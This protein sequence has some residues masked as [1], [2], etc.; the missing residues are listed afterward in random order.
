[1]YCIFMFYLD[2]YFGKMFSEVKVLNDI[3]N[4]NFSEI[5]RIV[6]LKY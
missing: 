3:F 4:V 1:M 2:Y 5:Y 6:F